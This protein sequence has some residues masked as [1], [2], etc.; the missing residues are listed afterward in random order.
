MHA[1]SLPHCHLHT[2]QNQQIN[3]KQNNYQH[4]S[5][6][7]DG[8]HPMRIRRGW[9]LRFTASLCPLPIVNMH[10]LDQVCCCVVCVSV[11]VCCGCLG[12]ACCVLYVVC[13][14]GRLPLINKQHN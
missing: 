7:F 12:R 10:A 5:A 3:T 2:K 4:N 1:H 9:A 11:C 13:G 14:V 6:S 8:K